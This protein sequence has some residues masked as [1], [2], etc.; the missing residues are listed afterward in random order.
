MNLQSSHFCKG[1]YVLLKYDTMH[2]V[3][4]K[5]T[6]LLLINHTLIICVIEYYGHTFYSH[7]NAFMIKFRGVVSAVNVHS[8]VD[9]RPLH[10]RSS[11]V[12]SDMN[13]Y[14]TLPYFY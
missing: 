8:L 4:G 2:P 9:H 10:A 3:F 11:F 1:L 14:I 5:I 7:Y 6:D 12:S 13:L